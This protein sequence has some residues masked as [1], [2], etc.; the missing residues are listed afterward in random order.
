MSNYIE[1]GRGINKEIGTSCRAMF[2]A[3][4]DLLKIKGKPGRIGFLKRGQVIT[5]NINSRTPSFPIHIWSKGTDLE[6]TKKI[7]VWIAGIGT[8]EVHKET[9]GG[10]D[11]FAGKFQRVNSLY[12][13]DLSPQYIG[14]IREFA[15]CVR[16]VGKEIKYPQK[17]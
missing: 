6:K 10:G 16:I 3:S 8:L 14:E 13:H 12:N 7:N 11:K 9:L 2:Q 5:H 4:I 1:Q 17:P 15:K